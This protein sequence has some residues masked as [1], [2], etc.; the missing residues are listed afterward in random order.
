MQS[1]SDKERIEFEHLCDADQLSEKERTRIIADIYGDEAATVYQAKRCKVIRV[2]F[3][4]SCN[5][6]A[7]I[8]M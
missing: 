7:T 3:G 1:L 6:P 5:T 8:S 2:N 4:N